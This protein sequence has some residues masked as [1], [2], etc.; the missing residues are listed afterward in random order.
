MET[1]NIFGM[2]FVTRPRNFKSSWGLKRLAK[3][4]RV[5]LG[6]RVFYKMDKGTFHSITSIVEKGNGVTV[7]S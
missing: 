3:S 6:K 5:D 7:V 1:F 2:E 4:W